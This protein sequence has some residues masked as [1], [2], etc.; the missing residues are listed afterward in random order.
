MEIRFLGGPYDGLTKTLPEDELFGRPVIGLPDGMDPTDVP[1]G[2]KYIKYL[3]EEEGIYVFAGVFEMHECESGYTDE[4]GND[5]QCG[6]S[7]L[8]GYPTSHRCYACSETW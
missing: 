5:H 7:H 8:D 6:E 2:T 4:D 3:P 1:A